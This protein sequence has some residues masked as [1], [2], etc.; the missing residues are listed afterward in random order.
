MSSEDEIIQFQAK[1]VEEYENLHQ[2]SF[3]PT[4]VAHID[5]VEVAIRS[6]LQDIGIIIAFQ[7][8]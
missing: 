4:E 7:A 5:D 2:G 1:A 3:G 8:P 6:V